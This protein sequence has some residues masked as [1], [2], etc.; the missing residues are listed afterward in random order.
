M[1]KLVYFLI[2]ILL[3]LVLFYISPFS[4]VEPIVKCFYFPFETAGSAG[5]QVSP[6]CDYSI[7]TKDHFSPFR[8]KTNEK[9]DFCKKNIKNIENSCNFK[10]DEVSFYDF[11]DSFDCTYLVL[12][13]GTTINK[14]F[15]ITKYLP[16]IEPPK[17][18]GIGITELNFS[19]FKI[20]I[21]SLMFRH[22]NNCKDLDKLIEN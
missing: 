18:Y 2:A 14:V 8:L 19:N 13:N 6:L 20:R 5:A 9:I 22:E 12:D 7:W 4:E 11:D 3:L 16:H 1:T 17:L 10:V 21:S 15:T